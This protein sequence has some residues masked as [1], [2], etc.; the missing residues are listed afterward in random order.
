MGLGPLVCVECKLY[1]N[2]VKTN[3]GP[4]EWTC[5]CCGTDAVDYLWLLTETEQT[6]IA[7]NSKFYRFVSGKDND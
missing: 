7:N 5:P 4:G 2:L 3:D 6:Q 1:T